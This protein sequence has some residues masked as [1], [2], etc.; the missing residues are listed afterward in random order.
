MK[1]DFKKIINIESR[2][3]L[4]KF[5]LNEP[6]FNNNYLFHYLIIFDKLDILKM[7]KIP[8]FKEND[9]GL[10]GFFLAASY[11][12]LPI[13]KYFIHNYKDYIYN[14]NSEDEY[15]IDHL[16][17]KNIIKLLN[18]DLDWN[19]LLRN[20]IYILLNN[21]NLAD[22]LK[23]KKKY[24]MENINFNTIIINNNLS[25]KEKIYF[26]ELYPNNINIKDSSDQNM[27]F[28]ALH[29]K[30]INL[31]KYLIKK[32]IE[33]DYYTVT[34]TFNP[35]KTSLNI[36]FYEAY[37]LIWN[38]IKDNFNYTLTNRYLDNIAHFILRR[39]S[40]DK[41]SLSILQLCPSSVWHQFNINKVTPLE[42]LLSYDF[43]KYNYLLKNKE[44]NLNLKLQNCD[45]ILSKLERYNLPNSIKWINYM[46][47]L[48]KFN[49]TNT[50]ILE[51]YKYTHG[52]LF[53]ARFKDVGF[54]VIHLTNKYENLYCPTLK[55]N[56]V[57]NIND[58]DEI[59][60]DWPDN[61]L[62]TKPI[63]P[64]IIF[65]QNKDIFWIHSELNN[66]INAIKNNDAYDFAFCY[67]SLRV[68]NDGLHA[69]VLIYDLNNLTVERFDP[70]GNS[71]EFDRNIDEVLEEE[72]TWNTGFKYL[73][74]S[75]YMPVSGFQTVSD[76]LNPLKEKPGDFG[77]FCLAWCCW[78]LE[79]RVK[80]KKVKP[81]ILV[82]KLLNKLSLN[83]Y[84]FID[85]IRNY[86][87]NLNSYR[88]KIIKKIGINSTIISNNYYSQNVENIIGNYLIKNNKIEKKNK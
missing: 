27:I 49:Q 41:I 72:L 86:A 37:E 76:E 43:K 50:I 57:D 75:D 9:D 11:N 45:T 77:G 61:L 28:A 79:H 88:F 59:N 67:L 20:K 31:I 2:G 40:T 69:N 78:Y 58:M 26:L 48:P 24:N 82:D 73:K 25:I 14:R 71:L 19:I 21:L 6:I 63:F 22:L 35:L 85:Y 29:L 17:N 7:Y 74:P 68:P 12:N 3:D 30:D 16:D 64:W 13:L 52:N 8:I 84:S 56:K 81:N 51:K 10:N 18:E 83:N 65:Y 23:L 34:D 62:E 33:L 87:N 46:K 5:K 47:K 4:K 38:K 44:I 53:Q 39:D 42:L 55:D 66:L 36:D 60:L 32:N 80:N 54:Y 15:F 1:I 70:Y